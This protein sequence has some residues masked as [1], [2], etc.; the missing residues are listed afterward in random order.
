MRL[1]HAGVDTTVIA[2]RLEHANLSTTNRYAE[3]NAHTKLAALRACE[4]PPT[5]AR[6]WVKIQ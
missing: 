5:P 2:L 3:I 6:H 4:P 1:L